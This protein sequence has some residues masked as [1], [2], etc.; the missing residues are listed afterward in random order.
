M[1]TLGGI[2]SSALLL[3]FFVLIMYL[4]KISLDE[5]YGFEY[6][7]VCPF[8]RQLYTLT[9]RSII[10]MMLTFIITSSALGTQS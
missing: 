4:N 10:S 9:K 6:E 7:L 5:V 3:H 1:F 2:D 8:L